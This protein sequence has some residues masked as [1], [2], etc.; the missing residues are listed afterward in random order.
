MKPTPAPWRVEGEDNMQGWQFIEIAAGKLADPSFRRIAEVQPNNEDCDG[1]LSPEDRANAEHIVKCVNMHEKLI[2]ALRDTLSCVQ[3]GLSEQDLDEE[4]E[5][6]L[7]NRIISAI[8][9]AEK[10]LAKAKDKT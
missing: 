10:L 1:N 5:L 6:A 9:I 2:S 4:E 8:D 7:G 3:D